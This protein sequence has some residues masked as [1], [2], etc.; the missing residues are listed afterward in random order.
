MFYDVHLM[1][2][3]PKRYVK[4]FSDA[5]ADLINIHIEACENLS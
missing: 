2:D 3:E 4:Q 1:I 5:G